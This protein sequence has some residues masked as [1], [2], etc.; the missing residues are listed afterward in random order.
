MKYLSFK[1]CDLIDKL[2]LILFKAPLYVIV[3]G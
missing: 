1:L 2:F 3:H